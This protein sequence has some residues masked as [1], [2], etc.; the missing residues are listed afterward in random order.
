M[1]LNMHGTV[2]SSAAIGADYDIAALSDYLTKIHIQ[3]NTQ[4]Q[5]FMKFGDM[6]LNIPQN[7]SDTAKWSKYAKLSN[8]PTSYVLTEGVVPSG[9]NLTRTTLT[10]QLTQLGN[11]LSYSD[12]LKYTNDDKVLNEMNMKLADQ[13]K[14]I[15]DI[16]VRNVLVA[17]T[18]VLWGGDATSTITVAVGDNITTALIKKAV[19]NLQYNRTK[20]SKNWSAGSTKVG[21][22][23]VG[24][25]YIGICGAYVE[26][27]LKALTGFVEVQSYASV[28]DIMEDEIGYYAGVRFIRTDVPYIDV[29]GGDSNANVHSVIIF[30]KEAYGI[31]RLEGKALEVIVKPDT[32]GG[33]DNPLNQFGTI[34]WKGYIASRILKQENIIRLE[35]TATDSEADITSAV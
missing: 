13:S 12:K 29:D 35:V 32:M 6:S 19:R 24:A 3:E 25:S 5:Q 7:N 16:F 34:G 18:N 27:D 33:H 8:D 26:A 30:G 9:D 20:K 10:S 21:S 2:D 28:G 31:T 4:N 11:F 1:A 15:M 14:E 22:S 17:G 23:P